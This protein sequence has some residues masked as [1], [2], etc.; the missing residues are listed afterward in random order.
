MILNL[1]THRG[2]GQAQVCIPRLGLGEEAR[3]SLEFIDLS[4]H[5]I[6]ELQIQRATLSQNTTRREIEDNTQHGPLTHMF[7]HA[8]RHVHMPQTHTEKDGEKG[9]CRWIH[10]FYSCTVDTC[11]HV[12]TCTHTHEHTHT[13][14]TG[15]PGICLNSKI[16]TVIFSGAWSCTSFTFSTF[17]SLYF[18]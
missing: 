11:P 9:W 18:V 10:S 8:H 2:I 6:I 1:R 13:H 3:G 17:H 5:S 12:H 4:A 16:L 14:L 7:T 15:L